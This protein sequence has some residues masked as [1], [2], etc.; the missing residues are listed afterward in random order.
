[1]ASLM[2][3]YVGAVLFCNG[4]WILGHIDD[5]ELAVIDFFV[6]ALGVFVA[7]H[8]AFTISL[9]FAA[10]IELAEWK[11]ILHH[12]VTHHCLECHRLRTL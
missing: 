2:L 10:Q 1:M 4:L 3:F 11:Y 7:I 6:G 5:K 9:L 12:P 8:G